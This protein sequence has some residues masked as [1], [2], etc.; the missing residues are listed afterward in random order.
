MQPFAFDSYNL[1]FSFIL[2]FGIQVILFAFAMTL[3]TDKL[4]DISYGMTFVIL[5]LFFLFTRKPLTF[6]QVAAAIIIILWGLRLAAYLFIR[7]MRI[8]RDTRFDSRRDSFKK[9]GFFWLLQAISIWTILLP[10]TFFFNSDG[11][12]RSTTFSLAGIV[13]WAIGFI[14]EAVA[15]QQ[16]FKFKSDEKNKGSWVNNG[17]WKYSR[18]PNYFGEILC[19]WGIFLL[20]APYLRGIAWIGILGPVYITVLLMFVSGIP[21]LEK[22]ADEKYKDNKEYQEYKHITSLLIPLR[23]KKKV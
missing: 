23:P 15:D 22:Q 10:V 20:T 19:W 18:H 1:L 7:I 9:F 21:L 5:V 4:T 12:G 8:G 13:V 14:I 6:L 3:H 17:L 16:K 2:I 11:A